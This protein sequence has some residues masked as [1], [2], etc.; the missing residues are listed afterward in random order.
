MVA[1]FPAMFKHHR[2][3]QSVSTMDI[4]PTFVELAGGFVHPELPLEGRSMVPHL[5]GKKGHDEVIGEYFGE[6]TS[7]HS[8]SSARIWADMRIA[9][10]QSHHCS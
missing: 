7:K 1:H 5:M 10:L 6:A 9:V 8:A 3:S 4:L 2:V